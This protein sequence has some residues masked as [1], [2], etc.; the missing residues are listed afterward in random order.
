MGLIVTASGG[1]ADILVRGFWG[2]SSPQPVKGSVLESTENPQAGKPALR[3]MA[4]RKV[5]IYFRKDIL[6]R[7][8]SAVTTPIRA[9]K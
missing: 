6:R 9:R 7:I 5:I 8:H 2:L 3:T 4:A 1:S